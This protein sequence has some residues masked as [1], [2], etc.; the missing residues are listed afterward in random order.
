MSNIL[1]KSFLLSLILL[2]PAVYACFPA[3]VQLEKRIAS[4][5]HI[6]V[7]MVTGIHLK[8][9]EQSINN[10]TLPIKTHQA[11]SVRIR[12][13][14]TLKGQFDSNIINPMIANCGYGKA[15][16]RQKVVVFYDA[17]HWYVTALTTPIIEQI[18]KLIKLNQAQ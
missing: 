7:G 16:L 10:P 1:F 11:Y 18:S 4:A 8:Q 3:N 15:E 12:L 13:T 14:E 17:N 2:A 5:Q 6:G 9:F